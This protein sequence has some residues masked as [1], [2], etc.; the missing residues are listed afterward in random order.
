MLVDLDRLDVVPGRAHADR[1]D[2]RGH[3]VRHA[4]KKAVNFGRAPDFAQLDPEAFGKGAPKFERD[5]AAARNER[6]DLMDLME[7]GRVSCREGVGP[8][9]EISG[10]A[11]H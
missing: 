3:G 5:G 10:G 1:T 7:I 6:P 4:T 11:G 8:Y 2:E 9:V